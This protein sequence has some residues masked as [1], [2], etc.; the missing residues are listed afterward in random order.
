MTTLKTLGT[1]KIAEDHFGSKS[2]TCYRDPHDVGD[3]KEALRETRSNDVRLH[4]DGD[5][6]DS[7]SEHIS[8]SAFTT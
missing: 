2:K 5:R 6:V 3:G 7:L 4:G 1:N 8:A